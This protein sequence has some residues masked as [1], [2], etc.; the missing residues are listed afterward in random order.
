MVLLESYCPAGRRKEGQFS[1]VFLSV[2]SF[3]QLC[4][5]SV[6]MRAACC[7]WTCLPLYSSVGT[8][9]APLTHTT[10]VSHSGGSYGSLRIDHAARHL[11]F[12]KYK[13]GAAELFVGG[14]V[15]VS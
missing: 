12:S 9:R 8:W 7:T 14:Q 11:K 3:M 15:A 10:H 4:F 2:F 5:F 13:V 6:T 1:R